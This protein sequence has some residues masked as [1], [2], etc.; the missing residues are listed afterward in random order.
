MVLIDSANAL[1]H[2]LRELEEGIVVEDP[3][4]WTPCLSEDLGTL[5]LFNAKQERVL[6]IARLW[7]FA[8]QR[9]AQSDDR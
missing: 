1:A 8:Q 2:R 9:S 4:V 5:G 3:T 6:W 7:P